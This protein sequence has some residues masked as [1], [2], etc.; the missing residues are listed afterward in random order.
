MT[1]GRLEVWPED[2]RA[3]ARPGSLSFIVARSLLVVALLASPLVFGAVQTW[4]WASLA[5]LAVVQVLFWVVG[6]ARRR[7]LAI[8]WSPLYLPAALFLLLGGFQLV[9]HLSLDPIGT[10]ESLLKLATYFLWF[11][12]AGQLAATASQNAWRQFALLGTIFAFALALFSILQFFSSQGLIYWS[13][14]TA[15]WSF[16]PY[17]NH[18]HYAGLMELLIP[19]SMAYVVS[20]PRNHPGRAMLAFAA[21]VPIVS[22]LLSGSRGGVLALLVEVL[23]LA[24]ILGRCGAKS[25]WRRLGIIGPFVLLTVAL[26]FFWLDPG[27]VA[28]RLASVFRLTRPADVGIAE[29]EAVALDSLRTLRQRPWAGTGLGS[30]EIAYPQ[31]QSFSSDFVWEHAHNDYAEALAES[32]LGGGLLILAALVMFFRLSFREMVERIGDEAGKIQL[33]F[34]LGCCGLLFHS[35]FDFNLHVPANAVWFAVCAAGATC[36]VRLGTRKLA[37]AGVWHKQEQAR[38]STS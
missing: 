23:I 35:G 34:A 37:L 28:G 27:E 22:V 18:N 7:E 20:R 10:R 15:A 24:M 33:G 9:R 36:W 31:Y 6:S 3:R 5:V 26:L 19:L 38:R 32:G 4:A 25:D 13:V 16:G 17:V 30:F 8:F 14:K 12:L 21:S 11:F 1:A 29:R 2:D